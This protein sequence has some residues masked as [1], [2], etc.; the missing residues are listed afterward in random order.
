MVCKNQSV[1]DE[2]VTKTWWL[3]FLTRGMNIKIISSEGSRG[4]VKVN[5][6]ESLMCVVTWFWHDVV[7]RHFWSKFIYICIVELLM[8]TAEVC[9]ISDTAKALLRILI[10][11]RWIIFFSELWLFVLKTNRILH[12]FHSSCIALVVNLCCRVAVKK[13]LCWICFYLPCLTG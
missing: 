5:Q 4:P 6:Q 12:V 9:R 7:L 2:V 1:F 13:S 10:F 3:S 8:S 11:L